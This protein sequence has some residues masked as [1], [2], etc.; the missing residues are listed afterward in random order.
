[1]VSR[2]IARSIK[3]SQHYATA[4]II[5]TDAC[6]NW[7]GLHESLFDK[8]YRVPDI[9]DGATK[10]ATRIGNISRLEKIDL[11]IVT[12]EKEVLF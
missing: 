11:A 7:F 1:M 8:I 12:P 2:A 3:L 6:K 9:G 5:A 4:R 10:Y